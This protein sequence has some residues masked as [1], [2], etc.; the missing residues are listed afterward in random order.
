MAQCRRAGIRVVMI[1]GDHPR[2]ARAIAKQAGIGGDEVLTGER[3]AAAG[4]AGRWRNEVAT[5]NIFARVRP[6]QK[7]ALIEALKASG[8]VVAMTGDG[9]NDAPA[10]KAAHIGI[11]MGQRGTDVA[12]EAA[13]LVLLQDDFCVHR[14]G[15]PG[16]GRRTFANLRQAMVY[17]LAV[18]VP[19]VGLAMLPV[20][21]GLPLVL[22]PLHIAFLELVIDPACSL[23]FEAEE[24]D[25]D[26][27]H[28]P[29]RPS[30][31][32]LLTTTHVT[33]SLLQGGLVTAMVVGVYARS[34][35][36]RDAR[37]HGQHG[38]LRGAGQRQCGADPAQPHGPY[39]LAQP[40]CWADAGQPLGPG[41][42]AAGAAGRHGDSLARTELRLPSPDPAAM[43]CCAGGWAVHGAAAA[44]EQGLAHAAPRSSRFL[45]NALMDAL[46]REAQEAQQRGPRASSS[47][48][49]NVLARDSIPFRS[50]AWP[51]LAATLLPP[52]GDGPACRAW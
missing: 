32:A 42:H 6:Q 16:M 36:P 10:L 15:H 26:L 21:F 22:A 17:T 48:S 20:L 23:V 27:M 46:P 33:Q 25:P 2:T 29:P 11:A 28:Q 37:R 24:G 31:A 4:R 47:A 44:P 45:V 13:S 1:T 8:E 51:L 30:G 12:R 39:R 38:G 5:V 49:E 43:A 52:R 50:C 35:A 9:V 18:H 14:A 40:G 19:I 34:A 7:L 3:L 41:L